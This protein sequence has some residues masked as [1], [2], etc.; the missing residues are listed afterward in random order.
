MVHYSSPDCLP[1]RRCLR[2]PMVPARSFH[3]SLIWRCAVQ[4]DPNPDT[5]G[6]RGVWLRYHH[7]PDDIWP[8]SYKIRVLE[9]DTHIL[10]LLF[11]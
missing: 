4:Q 3:S 11:L 5:A 7:L 9:Q 2:H 6:S 8:M 10:K 1:S